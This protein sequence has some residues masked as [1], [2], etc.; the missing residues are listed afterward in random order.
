MSKLTIPLPKKDEERLSRLAIRYG[1]SLPML[2]ARILVGVT[3]E[4]PFESLD[5]YDN[6]QGIKRSLAR[7]LKDWKSGK[8]T[9]QLT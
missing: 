6:P 2:A 3:Q 8:V 4:I 1:L 5:E 9:D 7:A